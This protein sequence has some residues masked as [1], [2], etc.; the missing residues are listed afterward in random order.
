M[1]AVVLYCKSYRNDVLRARSLAE[2]IQA[3]NKEQLPFLV[4]APSLDIPLFREHLSGCQAEL[5]SDEEILRAN[6]RLDSGKILA[7]PGGISQ[8]IV[9]SEFWRLASS[10]TY[11]CIDS[12]C[13]FIRPFGISDFLAPEGY[14]YTVMHEAKELLQFA[15][16]NNL[17]QI[18]DSFH[19]EHA[20]LMAMF[21]RKGRAFD[22]GPPPMIWS[23][24]VWKALDE[25]FLKPRAM[26]FCDAIMTFPAEIQWYG[27][28]ML[29]FRPFPLMPI[30]PLFKFYHYENQYLLG[31]QSGDSI[32]RLAKNFLG[33]CYQ[34]NWNKGVDF[35]ANR[36]SFPSRVWRLFRRKV[37]GRRT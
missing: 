25:H 20:I 3:F 8:Q 2:S 18:Y 37:L 28:A 7:L 23:A 5:I 24:Q 11:L 29:K 16:N 10:D 1:T 21:E 6:P 4:S 17:E 19:S 30:E 14:P 12:D 36:K 35:S 32:E 34:S 33:V 15:V 31:C 22:F 9:K 26:N 27:E 13:L